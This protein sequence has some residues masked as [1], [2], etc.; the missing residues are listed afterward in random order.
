MSVLLHRHLR[1]WFDWLGVV[2]FASEEQREGAGLSG[3][4]ALVSEM[5]STY[6]PEDGEVGV[7]FHVKPL[8]LFLSFFNG[9][10]LASSLSNGVVSI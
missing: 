10:K 6:M 1:A 2:W 4:A 7:P 3:E 9:E 8:Y 5:R